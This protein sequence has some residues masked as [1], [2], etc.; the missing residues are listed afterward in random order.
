MIIDTYVKL[1]TIEKMRLEVSKPPSSHKLA[2]TFDFAIG[3]KSQSNLGR[4]SNLIE[5]AAS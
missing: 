3:S 2:D 4:G 1:K 5:F